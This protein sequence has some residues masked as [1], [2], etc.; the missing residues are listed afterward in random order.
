MYRIRICCSLLL[1]LLLF[2]CGPAQHPTVLGPTAERVRQRL[3]SVGLAIDAYRFPEALAA[4]RDLRP[5]VEARTDSVPDT[6]RA[7]LYQYLSEL[8]S[9]RWMWFDSTTYYTER[10]EALL[11]NDAPLELRVRQL[12]V[13]ALGRANYDRT[14]VDI[15]MTADLG[16][17]LLEEADKQAHPLYPRLLIVRGNARKKYGDE[18]AGEEQER[19]W[20]KASRSIERALAYLPDT[21]VD[22][23][24]YAYSELGFVRTRQ[25]VEERAIRRLA[26]TLGRLATNQESVDSL[27]LLGHYFG[28]RGMADSSL[29][30][31]RQLVE[32]GPFFN[33][34]VDSEAFYQLRT[35][36]LEQGDYD[37]ALDYAARGAGVYGCCAAD[38]ATGTCTDERAGCVFYHVGYAQVLLERYRAEGRHA[39]LVALARIVGRAVTGYEAAFR[40][41]QEE[42]VLNVMSVIGRRMLDLSLKT[43]VLTA[44]HH[45]GKEDYLEEVFRAFERRRALLLRQELVGR[46]GETAREGDEQA[47]LSARMQLL[48]ARYA[49]RLSLPLAKLVDYQSLSVQFDRMAQ[50]SP[51]S[52]EKRGFTDSAPTEANLDQLQRHLTEEQAFISYA[53]IGD[54]L[55]TF[56]ADR[57]TAFTY[58]VD[59]SGL[60]YRA[61]ALTHWLAGRPGGGGQGIAEAR[62]LYRQL[63]RPVADRRRLPSELLIV[64]SA[65]I[66]EVSF[67][68]LMPTQATY[69]VDRHTV[70][71]LPSWRVEQ[72][73]RMRRRELVDR[74]DRSPAL[75]G[76]WTHPDLTAYFAPLTDY[77][78]RRVQ[79]RLLTTS[80][81]L[82]AAQSLTY[83]QLSVHARGNPDRLHDNYLYFSPTDSLNGTQ[84]GTY[85]LNARLAVLA[86]CSTARGVASPGEGTFSLQR[87]FHLAGVPDVVSSVYDIPAAATSVLLTEFYRR[88]LGGAEPAVAL[89]EAQ[90]AMRR[91]ELGNGRYRWVGFWGGMVVG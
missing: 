23:Q 34:W 57:D 84:L 48:K 47:D 51:A 83:L 44:E 7:R 85:R 66:R 50:P 22:W 72:H 81:P 55:Y 82:S 28:K 6:L 3:D 60:R 73:H 30:T 75:V 36:A 90:R 4:A 5:W 54:Q 80:L 1:T 20:D 63:L 27:R 39:D 24:R 88:L 58:S 56:Y 11:P 31:Y 87:S 70:R 17:A 46:A 12:Y 10:A 29:R 62:D 16:L 40:N 21:A 91:G 86:A 77:L 13:K 78:D 74:A 35:I 41:R 89:A 18:L 52:T 25:G 15:M 71:Y 9:K 45:G 53:E 38:S 49:K 69:L 43:A 26:D 8:H 61:R 33:Y 79:A 76:I 19:M 59:T 64:P 32:G 65:S 37:A 67:A 68:A 42:S 14:W 2:T